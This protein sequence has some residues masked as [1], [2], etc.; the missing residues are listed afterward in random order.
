M[1][2]RQIRE[3]RRNAAVKN[4]PVASKCLAIVLLPEKKQT[5]KFESED[6]GGDREGNCVVAAGNTLPRQ[7]TTAATSAA[8]SG[9]GVFSGKDILDDFKRQNRTCYW[10]PALIE[11]IKKL[12]YLGFVEPCTVLVVGEDI[13]LENLRSAWGRR[14][15][16]PPLNYTIDRIGEGFKPFCTCSSLSTNRVLNF[17]MYKN[18]Y[19][20]HA[21]RNKLA[22]IC[23]LSL[24]LG[25]QYCTSR[26]T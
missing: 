13:H 2:Q 16:K 7:S 5:Q 9:N 20:L 25:M 21:V 18:M 15:L 22:C 12:E 4:M 17:L 1:S 14:V 19:G 10:N 24:H 3:D 26:P 6:L 8:A 11:S 23:D